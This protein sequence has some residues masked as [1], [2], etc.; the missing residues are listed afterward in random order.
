M[1]YWSVMKDRLYHPLLVTDLIMCHSYAKQQANP[2]CLHFESTVYVVMLSFQLTRLCACGLQNS[3]KLKITPQQL[4]ILMFE[5]VFVCVHS[6]D[7]QFL[8]KPQSLTFIC[9]S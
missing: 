6:R 1:E 7:H 9:Y 8:I 5:L 4:Q 3:Q 2:V